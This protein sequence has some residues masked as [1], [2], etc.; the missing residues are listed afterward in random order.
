[1]ADL[2]D[3]VS[4]D[5]SLVQHQRGGWAGGITRRSRRLGPSRSHRS[6][7]T[8]SAERPGV[9]YPPCLAGAGH[10]SAMFAPISAMAED[11][12]RMDLLSAARCRVPVRGGDELA[13]ALVRK[14][15]LR[16]LA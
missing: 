15:P 4:L 3:V 8:A 12:Q 1:M 9:N 6:P 10:T 5:S 7:A 13:S 16:S 2:S 14:R 11:A